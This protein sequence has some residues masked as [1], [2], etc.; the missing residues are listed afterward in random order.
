MGI[1]DIVLIAAGAVLYAQETLLV[2]ISTMSEELV[3]VVECDAA[4]LACWVACESCSLVF[5]VGSIWLCVA[6][7]NVRLQLLGSEQCMFVCYVTESISIYLL[8]SAA[9]LLTEDLLMLCT[10]IAEH[11]TMFASRMLL[12]IRPSSTK[13][14]TVELWT[15]ET[16]QC[17]CIFHHLARFECD[18]Q[19][20]I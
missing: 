13:I 1:I 3:V 17:K 4:E 15:V 18:C 12:Q 7:L 9:A 20:S 5:V 8:T 14:V 10:Q 16:Q 19:S 11:Q 2:L 6:V